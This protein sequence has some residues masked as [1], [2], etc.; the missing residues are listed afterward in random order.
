V[1]EHDVARLWGSI[2]YFLATRSSQMNAEVANDVDPNLCS[3]VILEVCVGDVWVGVVWAIFVWLRGKIRVGEWCCE[4][5]GS[6]EVQCSLQLDKNLY[7]CVCVCVCSGVGLWYV[8]QRTRQCWDFATTV[9]LVH[10]CVCIAVNGGL[11]ST[12]SWWLT[13]VIAGVITT[14]LAES[15]CMRTEMKLIPLN[16]PSK[17]D[18]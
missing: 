1:Q 2:S 5:V 14:V 18:L 9:Y 12:A 16:V 7:L 10:T 17:V 15:L 4:V 11:A 13:T 8:V 6:C 3:I